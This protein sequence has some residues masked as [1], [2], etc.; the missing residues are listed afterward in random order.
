MYTVLYKGFMRAPSLLYVLF[1]SVIW[2]HDHL[3][4]IAGR[5]KMCCPLVHNSMDGMENHSNQITGVITR[6]RL[7]VKSN[8]TDRGDE[9]Y[10]FHLVYMVLSFFKVEKQFEIHI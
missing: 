4:L 8:Y 6:H 10:S 7:T 1:L 5:T 2:L 9:G 3:A